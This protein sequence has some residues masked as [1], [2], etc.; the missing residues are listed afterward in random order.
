MHAWSEVKGASCKAEGFHF[1]LLKTELIM[2][3][4]II[5]ETKEKYK[6]L[7]KIMDSKYHYL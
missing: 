5:C 1:V 2:Q 6:S 4:I 7:V 3:S